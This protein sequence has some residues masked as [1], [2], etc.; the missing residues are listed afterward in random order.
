MAEKIRVGII[1]CD[2]HGMW[3]GA[4]MDDPDIELLQRPRPWKEPYIYSWQHGLI[5]YYYYSEYRHPTTMTARKVEG[6]EITRIWDEDR[7]SAELFARVFRGR[8]KVCETANE[9]S[10]D[11][12]LVLIGDGNGDGS[13]HLKLARPGLEKG[14]P[15]FVDKPLASTVKDAVAILEMAKRHHAPVASLS[16]LQTDPQTLQFARRLPEIGRPNLGTV[17]CPTTHLAGLI[18]AVSTA[19]TVF[20]TG[21]RRVSTMPVPG[22]YVGIHLDYGDDSARPSQGVVLNSTADDNPFQHTPRFSRCFAAAYGS[23]GAIQGLVLD[24]YSAADG[25]S[26]ILELVRDMVRTGRSEPKTSD[27]LKAVAVCEAIHQSLQRRQSVE[28]AYPADPL[29]S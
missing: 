24:S 15:T 10:D 13:D 20:G 6:F 7:P 9:V 16:I 22:K 18:H 1:R 3:Y 17:E 11:V 29:E 21:V 8:P 26:V 27:M 14:V 25:A 28:V 23:H 5:H 2:I 4:L 12:D 19:H